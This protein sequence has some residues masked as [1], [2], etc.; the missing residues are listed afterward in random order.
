MDY[1]SFGFMHL[2]NKISKISDV[3]IKEEVFVGPPIRVHPGSET[4]DQLC[5][6]KK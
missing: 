2:K 5:E 4:E 6:V 1:N 3:K